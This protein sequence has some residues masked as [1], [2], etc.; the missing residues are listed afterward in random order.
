MT[1]QDAFDSF[2]FS[3]R[4]SDSSPKTISDYQ[5]T[6]RPFVSFIGPET[7]LDSLGRE[8]I[9]A[10]LSK[11]LKRP[12]SKATKASYIRQV[13]IFLRWLEEEYEFSFGAKKI[14]VPRSPRREV[15]IYS[16]DEVAMI[17]DAIRAESPWITARNRAVV[18]LM[19]DSGLRQSE[20]C[21]I[22]RSRISFSDARLIVRGKGDKERTVPM[23]RLTMQYI[24][25]Y[26]SLCPFSHDRLFVN[27]HG[28]P[29]SGN[30]VKLMVTKLADRLPFE[31]SSHKL[32]HN[33]A[34]NYC[35]DH[36]E[37]DDHVDIYKLMYIM[38]HE[39]IKTTQRY[40]HFA[41]EI[42]A[43]KGH[44]SHLDRVHSPASG[45]T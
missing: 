32:R 30:A 24:Q 27:R 9:Q 37:Q 11:L 7:P 34:T 41:Y 42:L 17:F 39:D 40:L 26:L 44:I 8:N 16:S 21:N 18:A 2:I 31:L 29:L 10:Y 33:F 45:E 35:I 43:S 4:L 13:K 14:K 38:G 3:R 6:I 20:V 22:L 23:G 1:M 36:L 19:Y 5:D 28:G 15:R 12:L 25:E